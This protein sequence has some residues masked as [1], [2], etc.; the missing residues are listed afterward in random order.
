M[1]TSTRQRTEER[2][3]SDAP[4]T[5]PE[6]YE[7]VN[8][9]PVQC[10]ALNAIERGHEPSSEVTKGL[11]LSLLFALVATAGKVIGPIAVQQITDNGIS[12]PGGPD[13]G[14]VT[15]NFITCAVSLVITM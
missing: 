3:G 1:S 4:K 7:S 14:F 12:G 5:G 8:L 15:T 6:H 9:S 13:L 10:E 11:W 2:T